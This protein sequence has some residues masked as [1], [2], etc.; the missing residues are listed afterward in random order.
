MPKLRLKFAS[1]IAYS[2][3]KSFWSSPEGGLALGVFLILGGLWF[4]NSIANYTLANLEALSR[5]H[6]VDATLALFSNSLDQLGIILMLVT[7]LTTMRAFAIFTN[8]GHFDLLLAW[9]LTR[10]EIVLGHFLGAFAS[11]VL[12]TLLSFL[13]YGI[14]ICLGVGSLKLLLISA[15]GF[16][17]LIAAFVSV[18]LAVS[19]ITGS[20]LSS[21]LCTLGIFVILWA[22]GWAAPYLSE[23][24]AILVQGLAFAPRLEHFNLGLL[25]L[26]DVLYFLTLTVV[27]LCLT[28]PFP[29]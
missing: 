17:L 7:P 26:N 28:K 8:G 11:L 4:Y 22:L 27:G 1:H 25:D 12:L 3:W 2:E 20:P 23:T 10:A 18:G 19:S 15:L 14:L 24:L 16:I 9:P 6:A 21:A 13:P 5:G 29:K